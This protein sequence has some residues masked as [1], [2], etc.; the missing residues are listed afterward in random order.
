MSFSRSTALMISPTYAENNIL[1]ISLF[2]WDN[3]TKDDIKINITAQSSPFCP[4]NC[5][6]SGTCTEKGCICNLGYSG[7]SCKHSFLE[8]KIGHELEYN[9]SKYHWSIF[10]TALENEIE[11]QFI[12]DT[13]SSGP[14]FLFIKNTYTG[15]EI[16]SMINHD[17]SY[18]LNSSQNF[19]YQASNHYIV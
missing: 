11:I 16:V 7:I 15:N 12:Y 2:S 14:V 4:Y 13:L 8:F 1:Y 19:H 9:L 17:D 3:I 5:H 6:N 10:Y 18:L